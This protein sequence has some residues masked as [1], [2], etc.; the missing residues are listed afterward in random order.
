MP[1]I[2]FA[3]VLTLTPL[4]SPLPAQEAREPAEITLAL[5]G[6][7]LIDGYGGEPLENS[8]V[9]VAGERIAA[10]GAVGELEVPPGARLVDT[11]GMT[12]M[13]GLIDLHVHFDI[14]GHSDYGYWFPAYESRMRDVVLPTAA[15]ILLDAGVTSVRDLGSDVDNIF[16]L[17]EQV[18]SGAIPGP[19]TFIAG[20]FLRKTATAF[21]SDD[22]VDTWVV[23]GP[24]DAREKVRRLVDM[25]VDLIKTQDEALSLEELR[26]I[27]D[28]AHRL[29][30]RVATHL[31]SRNAIR[32]ALEAGIGEW[33]TLEHIGRGPEPRYPDDIV[34]GILDSGVA[35]APTVIA[36]AGFK[37]IAEN[38]ELLDH[39][40]WERSLPPDIGEDVRRSYDGYQR[41]SLFYGA[42]NEYEP[43]MSKLRQLHE[44]GARFIMASDSGTRGN[45]HHAAAWRE[46]VYLTEIG[47]SP[48]ETILASTRWA[49]TVLQR[50]DLGTVGP[51]QLADI[52][53][54]D[55]DPLRSM[56]DMRNV[57]Q[58]VKGGAVVRRARVP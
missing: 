46:M 9:L 49:A 11:D 3:V 31:Y 1:K 35:M 47:L 22:Y 36:F 52:I 40:D 44:A 25:G 7:R 23:E 43:R 16:W 14:L 28:E 8:V 39:P 33:D 45:P 34:Q 57:V 41:H 50:R 37:E 56:R 54:V 38:P 26:A 5:V 2:L 51:G 17:K 4:V 15:E 6:G 13:P 10:V 21:V 30:K 19:R 42:V 58:V 53:V 18:S 48:M 12:V 24:E 55:G 29:G 27:Y 32:R 20:P